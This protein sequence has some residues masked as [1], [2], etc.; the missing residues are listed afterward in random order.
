VTVKAP[1][2]KRRRLVKAAAK[3][4]ALATVVG[5]GYNNKDRIKDM[6]KIGV[7]FGGA[8]MKTLEKFI[9]KRSHLNPTPFLKTSLQRR[10]FYSRLQ[11]KKDA[12]IKHSS[13][14]AGFVNQKALEPAMKVVRKMFP[15]AAIGIDAAS[16][17]WQLTGPARAAFM[18]AAS[19]Y[20]TKA[21]MSE[22]D[23]IPQSVTMDSVDSFDSSTMSFVNYSADTNDEDYMSVSGLSDYRTNHFTTR[24]SRNRRD[25]ALTGRR[26]YI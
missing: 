26:F 20:L 6:A 8:R 16:A 3:T 21:A 23:K 9:R 19:S 11:M 7:M 24:G 14:I 5:L 12:L 25:I 22:P 1:P 18:D 10:L 13:G 15:A 2:K 4:L 17:V